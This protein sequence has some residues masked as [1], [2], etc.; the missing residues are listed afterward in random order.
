MAHKIFMLL[1]LTACV[2]VTFAAENKQEA[3]G[4]KYI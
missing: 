4:Y 2:T 3:V 1:V